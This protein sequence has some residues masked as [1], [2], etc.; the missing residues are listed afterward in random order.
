[1]IFVDSSVWIDYFNGFDS[2]QKI[3]L[4]NCLKEGETIYIT[5]M[6]VSEI[7]SGIKDKKKFA[8]VK[9]A[10]DELSMVNPDFET[11]V[12]TAEIYGNLRKKGI[13]IR[14][15]IDCLIAALVMENDLSL[16]QKDRDFKHIKSHYSS[17]NLVEP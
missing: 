9:D 14:S 5:G 10:L 13:T 6:V 17:M 7:L 16:L 4:A 12:K 1:M 8:E 15:I 3:A 11:Y 2:P